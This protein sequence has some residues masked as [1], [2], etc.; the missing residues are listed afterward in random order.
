MC[1]TVRRALKTKRRE[2]QLKFY[3]VTFVLVVLYGSESWV[4]IMKDQ[5][6]IEAAEMK[7]LRAVRGVTRLDIIPN[8][9]IK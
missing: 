4:L 6:Q 5:S 2:T 8:E 1:V 7:I 3:K 9:Q